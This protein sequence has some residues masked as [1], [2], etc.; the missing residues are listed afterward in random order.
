M[1]ENIPV[2]WWGWAWDKSLISIGFG[3][4]DEDAFFLWEWVWNSETPLRS[5]ALPSLIMSDYVIFNLFNILWMVKYLSSQVKCTKIFERIL[6][7]FYRY[8][9][10]RLNLFV[11]QLILSLISIQLQQILPFFLQSI[12]KNL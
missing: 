9:Y 8:I 2:T 10:C 11:K 7:C 1:Y 3:Y 12:S 4:M 5:A 6:C